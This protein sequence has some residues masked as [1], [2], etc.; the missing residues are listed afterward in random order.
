MPTP[1]VA[2]LDVI[3]VLNDLH[4][5]AMRRLDIAL[6]EVRRRRS[7]WR[8]GSW[9]AEGGFLPEHEIVLASALEALCASAQARSAGTV[10]T[11]PLVADFKQSLNKALRVAD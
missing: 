7:T 2:Q 6:L 1:T 10:F 3:A 5:D 11:G 4:A 8:G 9:R